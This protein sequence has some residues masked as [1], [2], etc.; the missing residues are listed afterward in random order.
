[1]RPAQ[2]LQA[3]KS[4]Y[5]HQSNTNI[6]LT[7]FRDQKC[8]RSRR[9][10]RTPRIINQRQIAFRIEK[11]NWQSKSNLYQ[12]KG[13]GSLA[14]GKPTKTNPEHCSPDSKEMAVIAHPRFALQR[15][16]L[17]PASQFTVCSRASSPEQKTSY[18]VETRATRPSESKRWW[19]ISPVSMSWPQNYSDKV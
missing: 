5:I 11:S 6:G 8:L 18:G 1:M 3:G 19:Q 16:H 17:L 13:L 4:G 15:L 12:F 9:A 2:F 7:A 10:L 14:T